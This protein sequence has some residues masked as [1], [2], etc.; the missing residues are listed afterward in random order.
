MQ[1][2][3]DKKVTV[4]TGASQNHARSLNQFLSSVDMNLFNCVV[5]DLGLSAATVAEL[6]RRYPGAYY[7][8]FNY[9]IYP[10]YYDIRINA[11]EYAWKPAI[12]KEVLEEVTSTDG[13]RTEVLIWCD[14]GNVIRHAGLPDLL[15]V[16]C[17]TPVYS[18]ASDG[19][20][21]KWTHPATL[22]WFG[23]EPGSD[24]L[25]LPNRNGAILAFNIQH[26]D[27]RSLIR[28]FAECAAT[29]E[30]I[31]PLGSSRANHRQDQAVFTILYWQYIKTHPTCG[32][33]N[34]YL[35]IVIHRDI[36]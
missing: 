14:A 35:N 8:T 32:I 2:M 18:P 1:K 7:R 34:D 30:C 19:T 31:A 22:S 24:F 26:E 20:I 29:R 4:V 25:S 28:K 6:Q 27:M 9:S 10:D 13:S 5:Y 12:L 17:T 15:R 33:H 36:D 23:V 21:A 11:G 16:M 3:F